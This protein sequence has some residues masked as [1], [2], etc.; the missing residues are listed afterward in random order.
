MTNGSHQERDNPS[1]LISTAELFTLFVKEEVPSTS[2]ITQAELD[3]LASGYDCEANQG[4]CHV[5]HGG[6]DP[7]LMPPVHPYPSPLSAAQQA[8]TD[9]AHDHPVTVLWENGAGAV[10]V[11][12]ADG[13]PP[14]PTGPSENDDGGLLYPQFVSE[15]SQW[16]PVEVGSGTA[17]SFGDNGDLVAGA[18]PSTESSVTYRYDPFAFERPNS[19]SPVNS[20]ME[21]NRHAPWKWLPVP[22]GTDSPSTTFVSESVQEP[23]FYVGRAYADLWL[24][25]TV[26]G[27]VPDPVDFDVEVTLSEVRADGREMYIEG[28]LQRVS[29]RA[30]TSESFGLWP[31][32]DYTQTST[33]TP[34][35]WHRVRVAIQPFAHVLRTGS[36]LKVSVKAPGG[37]QP[38]WSSRDS[39]A[40]HLPAGTTIDIDVGIGGS[41]ASS[42]VLPALSDT[43]Q[44]V[45]DSDPRLSKPLPCRGTRS[46]PC[47][48]TPHQMET[49]HVE[50]AVGAVEV[51]W[52]PALD[53]MGVSTRVERSTD[54]ARNG[55]HSLKVTISDKEPYTYATDPNHYVYSGPGEA[56]RI[57]PNRPYRSRVHVHAPAGSS[58]AGANAGFIG[59]FDETGTYVEPT[60]TPTAPSQH[61]P[62]RATADRST[63]EVTPVLAPPSSTSTS[64]T[65]PAA[66]SPARQPASN[67]STPTGPDSAREPPPPPRPLPLR[68]VSSSQTHSVSDRLNSVRPS[69]SIEPNFSPTRPSR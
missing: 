12:P 53:W 39:Q 38:L 51:S 40:G 10:P 16:P 66:S 36:Q 60:T 17:V 52:R 9:D 2:T 42:V 11:N 29:R 64:T 49:P 68:Y 54:I 32:P 69:T 41:V 48:A 55:S 18:A 21:D 23:V 61:R 3:A 20:A 1:S 33:V 44:P 27:P 19:L 24:R 4:D 50:P 31:Q 63:F 15:Y 34:G 56:V 58:L 65:A 59:F 47:R 5:G 57:V 22:D 25:P 28:G 7:T 8:W 67:L 14:V 62:D 13:T 6:M 30:L 43:D 46:Q 35:A 26:S 45:L 37:D